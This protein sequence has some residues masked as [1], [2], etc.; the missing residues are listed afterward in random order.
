FTFRLWS[1]YAGDP[2]NLF[3]FLYQDQPSPCCSYVDTGRWALCSASPE[4]FFALNGSTLTVRPM[5]RV[6]QFLPWCIRKWLILRHRTLDYPF[7]L[8]TQIGLG[9]GRFWAVV[10]PAAT[11]PGDG[12]AGVVGSRVG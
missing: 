5:T 9:R 10:A 12:A 3:C 8:S 7:R 1:S 2:W 11:S 4:L 6:S